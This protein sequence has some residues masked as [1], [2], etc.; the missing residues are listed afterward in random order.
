MNKRMIEQYCEVLVE[1]LNS[2]E[3]KTEDIEDKFNDWKEDLENDNVNMEDFDL[4]EIS[5]IK[6]DINCAMS[7]VQAIFENI[8]WVFYSI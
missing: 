1:Y 6:S 2:I 8:C 5:D 7:Y 4:D 3:S